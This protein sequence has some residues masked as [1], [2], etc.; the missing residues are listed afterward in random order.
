ME[1]KT[2]APEEELKDTEVDEPETEEPATPTVEDIIEPKRA[3]E[4]VPL[5]TFLE[6]KK[7][8]KDLER[9]IKYLKSQA[10]DMTKSEIKSDLQS[11]A[12]KYDVDLNFLNELSSTIYEQAK[13]EAEKAIKPVLEKEAKERV[14][15]ALTENINKA[16]EV[17]PEYEG[18]V[19]KD[20]LKSL[21]RLPENKNKTFQQ[22]IEE[23][24][25][26][27]VTGKKTME[28]STPRG[29]K[30]VGIDWSRVK[31][32]SYFSQIMADPELKK[33]YNEK[34]ISRIN[35]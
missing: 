13:E 4:Q 21:A 8:K 25:S 19:N 35:L 5:K 26:Q 16:L 14:D 7:E 10:Q 31:D 2:I 33:Q 1:E 27:T 28:T 23:T 6:I 22:L 24:Y 34:L 17:M 30:D 15:K 29:G 20:V 9:E 18:V 3:E 12:D 32:P 11:I